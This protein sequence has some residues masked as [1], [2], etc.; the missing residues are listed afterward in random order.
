MLIE[1]KAANVFQCLRGLVCVYKPADVKVEQVRHT[2]LTKLSSGGYLMLGIH[3][4][5]I[6]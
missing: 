2:I 4:F 3:K 1:S 5:N 6:P